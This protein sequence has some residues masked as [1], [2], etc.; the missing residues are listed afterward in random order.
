M[1]NLLNFIKENLTQDKKVVNI[2]TKSKSDFIEKPE[3]EY[4]I[5]TYK[6]LGPIILDKL[7]E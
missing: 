7:S 3:G 5:E 4:L 6:K 1:T 2:F